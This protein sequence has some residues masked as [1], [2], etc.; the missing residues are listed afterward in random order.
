MT[1]EVTISQIQTKII[2]LPNRPEAMLA[3]DLAELYGV[4]TRVLNQ[5]MKRNSERFPE[6][7]MFQATEIER[8]LLISQNVMSKKSHTALPF[9]FTQMGANQLSS[10]LKSKIAV[11]R[12]IQVMRAF[13]E[14]ERKLQLPDFTNPAEAA[15]AWANEYKEKEKA[16]I[17]RDEAIKTKAWISSTREASTMGKLSGATRRLKRLEKESEEKEKTRHTFL[18]LDEIPW[19]D[20]FFDINDNEVR[21]EIVH[22]LVAQG[23]AMNLSRLLVNNLS[24]HNQYAYN[25]K[26]IAAFRKRLENNPSFMEDFKIDKYTEIL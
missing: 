17:E 10:I 2:K 6:D 18:E 1:K 12:S 19:L 13:S 7:F 9:L 14:M 15:I 5:A 24:Y 23:A 20:D 25:T 3:Q 4:T 8:D 26:V 22:Q 11:Q 16:L 21:Y